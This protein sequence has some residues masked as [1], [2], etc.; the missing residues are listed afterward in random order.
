MMQQPASKGVSAK[1]VEY[2]RYCG[3]S[4]KKVECSNWSTELFRDLGV[5]GDIAEGFMEALQ[6]EYSVDLV[7]FEFQ[8]FFPPEFIGNSLGQRVLIWLI[9]VLGK[10]K[11]RLDD[12]RPITLRMI[13]V[14][15]REHSWS[16][17]MQLDT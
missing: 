4:A 11:R 13:D 1:V 5:Y 15:I 14:A 17:A 12:Y 16:A 9:P 8:D 6:D 7:D 2:L 10:S 3:I